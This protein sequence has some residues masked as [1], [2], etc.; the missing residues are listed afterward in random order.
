MK[1]ACQREKGGTI[2][3]LKDK[4]ISI[5]GIRM[6]KILILPA[7]VLLMV[8]PVPA[9]AGVNLNVGIGPPPPIVAGPPDMIS[10]P[11]ASGIYFAPDIG[12]DLFFWNGWWRRP[13]EGHWY[14][15]RY[16]D[17]GRGYYS[18]GVPGF[19]RQME[20]GWRGHYRSHRWNGHPW[21]YRRIPHRQFGR[22]R[23]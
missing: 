15:S 14:R 1:D 3:Y 13:W 20:P 21:N 17:R 11:G 6:S 18:R 7:A 23:R 4:T 5:E 2:M 8:V 22:H 12:A 10:M 16:Y 19:Y 9:M